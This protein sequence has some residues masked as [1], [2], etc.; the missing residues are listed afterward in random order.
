MLSSGTSSDE[1]SVIGLFSGSSAGVVCELEGVVSGDFGEVALGG[2]C[3][4]GTIAGLIRLGSIIP[5]LKPFGKFTNGKKPVF[6]GRPF[7]MLLFG[8]GLG[9]LAPGL[10]GFWFF[11]FG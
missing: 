3:W 9:T 5:I 6:G 4:F 7:G 2:C 1:L 11:G 8:S 10:G